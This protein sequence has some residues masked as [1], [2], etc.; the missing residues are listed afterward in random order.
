MVPRAFEI[1]VTETSRVRSAD[2][3]LHRVQFDAA[4]VVHRRDLQHDA[5]PVAQQLPRHDV[6]VML[7]FGDHHLVAG[8]QEI[9]GR[10]A[11]GDQVHRLGAA[12][13]E[14]DLLHRTGVEEAADTFPRALVAVRRGRAQGV[15]AAMHVGIVVLVER[16]DRLD[17]LARLLRRGR[18][19]QIDQRPAMNLP[20]Q[21]RKIRP[22]RRQVVVVDPTGVKRSVRRRPGDAVRRHA[23][24]S[25]MRARWLSSQA[26][27]AASNSSR[28]VSSP[29]SST[30]SRTKASTS[31]A[32]ASAS[33]IPRERR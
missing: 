6:G 16:D 18:I 3:P 13:G 8:G 17:H 4:P 29:I 23:A 20:G 26:R 30:A 24:A 25:R 15:D 31:R 9:A 11:G 27:I 10:Q 19:V 1:W 22:D 7:Q 21:D 32:R 5:D 2:Q 28:A 33:P 12:L 14:H